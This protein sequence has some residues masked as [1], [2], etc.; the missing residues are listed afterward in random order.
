MTSVHQNG[1]LSVG[2]CQMSPGRD[3][4]LLC[5]ISSVDKIHLGTQSC[6]DVIYL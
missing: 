6:L 4:C 3:P 2:V 1:M 5:N